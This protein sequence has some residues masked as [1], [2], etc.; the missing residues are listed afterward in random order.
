MCSTIVQEGKKEKQ[1]GFNEGHVQDKQGLHSGIKNGIK[2][3]G[4]LGP[5]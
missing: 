2:Y 3:E 5:I 4:K 1:M